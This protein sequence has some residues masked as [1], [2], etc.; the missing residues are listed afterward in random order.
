MMIEKL[1]DA[2]RCI[3]AYCDDQVC[4]RCAL[5]TDSDSCAL[6]RKEPTN[7]EIVDLDNIRL[8]GE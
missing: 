8:L 7:W 4:S 5:G 1:Y 2:L 6:M 3:Q